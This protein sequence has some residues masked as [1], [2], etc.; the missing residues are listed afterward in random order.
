MDVLCVIK[1]FNKTFY[2]YKINMF[3]CTFCKFVGKTLSFQVFVI[4][5]KIINFVIICPHFFVKN[6]EW[7]DF[8]CHVILNE[9]NFLQA[10]LVIIFFTSILNILWPILMDY[11]H[12]HLE[13]R[14]FHWLAE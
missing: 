3:F 13:T 8:M 9:D 2:I 6:I 10:I 12:L 14:P 1:Y 11:G 4:L 5:Y 7:Y